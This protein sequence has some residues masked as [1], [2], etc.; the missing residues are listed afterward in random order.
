VPK[1]SLS[2]PA[3]ATLLGSW[4]AQPEE[5]GY[6]LAEDEGL[7]KARNVNL[8]IKPGG[9]GVDP[10]KLVAVGQFKF[11]MAVSDQVAQARNEG[12]P[13]VGI[14]SPFQKFAQIIMVHEES[15]IK[16]FD[17]ISRLGTRVAVSSAAG[18]S[19]YLRKKYNW[20]EDQILRYNGQIAE[21]LND[22]QRATQ[23]LITNE[24]YLAKQ[25]G[26]NPRSLLVADVSGYNPY[27]KMLFTTE[28]TIKK[29]PELVAA[30]VQAC[31]E[32]W[33]SYMQSPEKTNAYL[34]T[35]NPDLN[36]DQMKFAF[37]AMKPLV[38]GGD[39]VT[40]GVGV[41]T[42]ARWDELYSQLKSVDLMKA[43]LDS[44]AAWT[45]TFYQQASRK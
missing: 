7:F 24:P 1:T 21:W 2:Q 11:G 42:Q 25:A 45:D 9:P 34:K 44:K 43:D 32:G 38:L 5:G 17:D 22:K 14:M 35:K 41:M 18:F 15:G 39:A 8:T 4:F 33:R 26:A 30:V 40:G 31:V 28:D 13:V 27:Q 37:E 19:V 16:D 10:V 3:E 20:K 29:E 12:V 23:G 36:D 6:Y